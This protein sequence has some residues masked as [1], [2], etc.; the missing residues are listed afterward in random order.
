MGVEL[1]DMCTASTTAEEAYIFEKRRF[2][3][4]QCVKDWRL[5]QA[6]ENING[7]LSDL[8]GATG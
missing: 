8:S 6:L 2:C 3:S 5:L 4:P 7:T 1:C